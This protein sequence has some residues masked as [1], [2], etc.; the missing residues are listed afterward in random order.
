METEYISERAEWVLNWVRAT[1]RSGWVIYWDMAQGLGRLGFIAIALDWE[2]AFLGALICV[3]ICHIGQDG[4][5]EST[6][7]V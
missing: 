6:S 7:Y 1:V 4:A 3:V 5:Y 2:R